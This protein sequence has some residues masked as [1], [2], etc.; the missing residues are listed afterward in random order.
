M[1]IYVGSLRYL[2]RIHLSP[3][4]LGFLG[5]LG[6]FLLI[7]LFGYTFNA[8]LLLLTGIAIKVQDMPQEENPL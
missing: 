4:F 1:C 3:T 7:F 6:L 8:D 5:F 2:M